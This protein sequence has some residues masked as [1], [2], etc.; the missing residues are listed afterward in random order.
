[1][2]HQGANPAGEQLQLEGVVVL[3]Q[4]RVGP[5]TRRGVVGQRAIPASFSGFTDEHETAPGRDGHVRFL[6][7]RATALHQIAVVPGVRARE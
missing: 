4:L 3:H 1:V 7:L 6:V 5:E 2:V